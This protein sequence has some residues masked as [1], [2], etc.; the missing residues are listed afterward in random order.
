MK[1]LRNTVLLFSL[2]IV[3]ISCSK[4]SDQAISLIGKWNLVYDSTFSGVGTINH[5][6]N[7]T[8]Q[9][10]DYFNFA[11][12]SIIYTKEGFVLDTL[13]YRLTSNNTLIISSFGIILNGIP[14]TS[15]ITYLTGN[16]LTILAPIIP[17]PAGAF[18]RKVN[19]S[20]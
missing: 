20:R 18:G 13:N 9:I 11:N 1:N 7:Y 14:E 8:G 16:N 12:D 15:Q 19:L 6:V 17:T 4:S 2:I 10:G 3:T 5:A